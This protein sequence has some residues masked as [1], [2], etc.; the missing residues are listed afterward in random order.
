MVDE[1]TK[2][3]KIKG[4]IDSV[5]WEVLQ[6][7]I[8]NTKKRE[9]VTANAIDKPY[10]EISPLFKSELISLIK[11]KNLIKEAKEIYNINID[12]FYNKNKVKK[13]IFEY[14]GKLLFHEVIPLF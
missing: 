1:F 13:K 12:N 8:G 11:A 14:E 10:L 7:N 4:A 3:M 9:K 5:E 2:S 6:K